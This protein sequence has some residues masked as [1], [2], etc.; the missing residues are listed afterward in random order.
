MVED[1]VIDEKYLKEVDER[2]KMIPLAFDVVLKGVFTKNQDLLKKFLICVLNLDLDPETTKIHISNTELIKQNVKEYQKR[3][4][5]LVVINEKFT[6]DI[7][8]NRSPFKRVKRRNTMYLDKVNTLILEVGNKTIKVNDKFVYQLNLNAVDKEY[9]EPDDIVG[10][11]S[12]KTNKI[13]QD[14]KFIILKYLVYY[15]EIYY[16]KDIENTVEEI[17]LAA[18]TA[19][20]FTELNEILSHILT[21]EERCR[22]IRS[23]IEMSELEFNLVEWEAEK[24]NQM[25]ID[26]TIDEGREEGIKETIINMLKKDIPIITISEVTGKTVE[27]IEALKEQI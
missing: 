22:F 13:Y 25:V 19:E 8:A 3:V 17:W 18:L 6:V 11:C 21:N 14:N 20:N 7:E 27:E 23:A 10:L 15:R 5:I 24:L 4:D 26:D 12:L 2:L 1:I 9:D 16:N